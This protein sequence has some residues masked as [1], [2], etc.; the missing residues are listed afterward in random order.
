MTGELGTDELRKVAR[1]PW[2][3]C[4]TAWG[5][6]AVS[7]AVEEPAVLAV[8]AGDAADHVERVLGRCVDW[9]RTGVGLREA[10]REALR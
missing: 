1:K 6:D 9:R 8:F 5:F 10:V 2:P 4:W 7:R 3:E